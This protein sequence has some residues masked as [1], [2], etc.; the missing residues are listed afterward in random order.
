MRS[1]ALCARERTIA[2]LAGI[3]FIIAN[4]ENRDY[5]DVMNL[6]ALQLCHARHLIL[7]DEPYIAEHIAP[8]NI[9]L[10]HFSDEQCWSMFRFRK[11]HLPDV[12]T[13]L[14]IH[15]FNG[16]L[17]NGSRV[18]FNLIKVKITFTLLIVTAT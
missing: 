16:I 8:L 12:M 5:G 11:E 2:R 10:N 1:H 4:A 6:V 13:A 7:Y 18:L 15:D 3:L 17:S 14:R 9:T